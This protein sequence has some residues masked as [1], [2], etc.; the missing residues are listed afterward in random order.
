MVANPVPTDCQLV[1]NA[2]S[3][4]MDNA[5]L[6][7][8]WY[9]APRKAIAIDVFYTDGPTKF[10]FDAQTNGIRA[11]DGRR[12]LVAQ[13]A[14]SFEWWTRKKPPKADMLSAVE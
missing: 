3:A 10:T 8:D 6:P 11:F 2:T 1:L 13:G 7:V 12:L 4:S 9:Q 14:R 5:H